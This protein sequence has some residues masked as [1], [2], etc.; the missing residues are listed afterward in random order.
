MALIESGAES[1]HARET[2]NQC[3]FEAP[4]AT[5]VPSHA[6]PR[7]NGSQARNR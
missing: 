1:R 2:S 3:P 4:A 7:P 6:S 5:D